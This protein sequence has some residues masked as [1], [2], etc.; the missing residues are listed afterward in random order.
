M[1]WI[2]RTIA[3]P[4]VLVF[5]ILFIL[6]LAVFRINATVGNPDF[7]IDQLRQADVYNFIYEEAL[8][9]ALEEVESGG[10]NAEAGINIS[11]L[12][13]HIIDFIQQSIPPDWLQLQVEN[14]ISKVN[15]IHL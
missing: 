11:H 12:K 10:D 5:I 14:T 4:L 9:V 7:Y 3:L 6:F 8:P 2:R 15:T 13:P 1:I